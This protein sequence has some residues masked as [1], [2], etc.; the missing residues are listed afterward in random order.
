MAN[1]I[2]ESKTAYFDIVGDEPIQ[3]LKERLQNNMVAVTGFDYPFS[4]SKCKLSQEDY[5]VIMGIDHFHHEE[6]PVGPDCPYITNEWDQYTCRS[7]S[8][9][10]SGE[11]GYILRK[12]EKLTDRQFRLPTFKEAKFINEIKSKEL[13]FR[14]ENE[15]C[16]VGRGFL[17]TEKGGIY[18]S[19][20]MY[21]D[22][23]PYKSIRLVECQKTLYQINYEDKEIIEAIESRIDKYE[24]QMHYFWEN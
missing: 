18:V 21:N 1:N 5:A 12:L 23:P 7:G 8:G 10:N 15:L 13:G 24:E 6:E 22:H 2:C 19:D 14:L 11:I 20:P 16:E 17:C 3:R 4:I 9:Q